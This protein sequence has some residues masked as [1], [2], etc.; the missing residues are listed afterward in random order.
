VCTLLLA[1]QVD[2]ARPLVVAANRDEF[3]AR[4]SERAA[5][6]PDA[7]QV[8]AGRD[9]EGGGTWL[10]VTRDGRFAALT[11][12]REP[13]APTPPQAPSRGRLVAE[14]LL[15]RGAPD[16][17]LAGLRP[18]DYAGFNLVVGDGRSLW[19]LSNRAG[20]ARAL[21]PGVYGVSNAALD[22]PWPKLLRGRERLA[23][24]VAGGADLPALLEMLEDR[25]PTAD[26]ELPDTGVGLAIERML[27]PLFIASPAYGTCSSTALVVHR[28]G[29]LELRERTQNPLAP[30]GPGEVA[31]A[32]A[33]PPAA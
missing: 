4:P 12:V 3:Y 25:S 33:A 7:P 8:L 9:L 30:A 22:T 6:W 16:E 27:S 2:P 19:Y 23:A 31:Y 24:L 26:A 10:G 5:F 13:G 14:F 18:A 32:L 11:N 28:D 29:A 21:G 20:P 1:W 15:A 17:Y